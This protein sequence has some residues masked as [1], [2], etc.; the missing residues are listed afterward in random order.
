MADGATITG[1]VIDLGQAHAVNS[2]IR[3]TYASAPAATSALITSQLNKVVKISSAGLFSVALTMGNYYVTID[4]GPD[5]WTISVPDDGLTYDIVGRIVSSVTQS[6]TAPA[7]ASLPVG[8][9]TTQGKL[10]TTKDGADPRASVGVWYVTNVAALKT[11]ATDASNSF[12][13][14]V[15]REI[16]EPPFF[17]WDSASAAADDT[18]GFTVV[19]PTDNPA[20]GRWIQFLM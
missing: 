2:N 9:T 7:G 18:V 15:N 11:I 10:K 6:P 20:T 12:A 17:W 3:F 19:K 14:L 5:R 4:S 16:G 1:R 8:S 13:T